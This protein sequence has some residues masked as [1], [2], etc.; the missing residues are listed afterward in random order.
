M[1][2]QTAAPT[3]ELPET[4]KLRPEQLKVEDI[5]VEDG[6]MIVELYVEDEGVWVETDAGDAG[7]LDSGLYRVNRE[8]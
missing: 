8:D 1:Q 4:H 7:Y 6:A 5:F 3:S 2:T